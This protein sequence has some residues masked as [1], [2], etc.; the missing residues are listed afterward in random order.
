[1]NCN[2]GRRPAARHGSAGSPM[3]NTQ[4]WRGIIHL[5]AFALLFA[6]AFM[7]NTPLQAQKLS[8]KQLPKMYREWLDRD[9]VYIITKEERETSSNSPLMKPATSSSIVFG[10]FVIQ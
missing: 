6:I 3:R 10:R 5:T 9:V 2:E 4:I 8:E 7:G 1:M